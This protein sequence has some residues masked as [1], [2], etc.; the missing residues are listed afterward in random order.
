MFA[1][2]AAPI[3]SIEDAC[4][5]LREADRLTAR[6][7]TFIASR[8]IGS[9]TGLPTE[10]LLVLGARRTGADARAMTNAATTLRTMPAT[11]DAFCRGD[12]S[13]SQMRAITTA[14]RS[15]DGAG[16]ITID[17]MI[18]DDAHALS[19]MD[20]D[21]LVAKVEDAA[22]Q[23]RPDLSRAREDR[24][25]ERSFLAIQ[26]HLDG[27]ASFYGEADAGSTATIVQAL[28]ALAEAPV[29]PDQDDAPSRAHQRMDAWVGMCEQVLAG[30]T[31]TPT[32]RPRPRLIATVDLKDLQLDAAQGATVLWNMVGRPPRITPLATQTLLCDATVQ[33]VIF[34][35]TRPVAVGDA[36]STVS[37]TLRTALIARDH[38]CRFPG[39]HAPVD[40]CDAHHIKAR[41]HQGPTVIDNLVLLCRRCHR[42]VHRYRWTITMADDGTIAFDRPGHHHRSS[43]AVHPRE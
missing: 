5:A 30:T 22:S 20:P 21:E 15:V 12:L 2:L 24:Q 14:V 1:T 42:R 43:P 10:M 27:S 7:L 4:E 32:T 19:Q 37:S 18:Q 40:W 6:A 29:A 26:G 34:H 8:D 16:R 3:D 23:L 13:W 25:I 38:G 33:P 9:H 35:G 11:H 28:D 41:I 17:Q 39:C 31:T 36:T